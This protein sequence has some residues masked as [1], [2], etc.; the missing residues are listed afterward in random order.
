M[1]ILLLLTTVLASTPDWYPTPEIGQVSNDWNNALD[2]AISLLSQLTLPEKVNITTGQ[3]D[4]LCGGNT[5]GVPR[6]GIKGLCLQDGPVGVRGADFVN[7]FPCQNAMAATFDRI[8]TH[9]RGVAIGRQSRLKGVDVHL[10][11]VVGPIGRHVAGGRNWEG[12]SPDPYLSGQLVF[13]A[14]QGVQEEHVLATVKHFVGNEQERFRQLDEWVGRFN[15]TRLK[16]EIS[17]NIDD[18]AM[19]ELYMWPFAD[20]VRA[21]VAAVMCSYNGVNGTNSCQNSDLLNGRLKSEL[22]FQGFVMSDWFAQD[23]GVSNALAGLDMS[24]P[25]LKLGAS[26]PWGGQ[27]TRMVANGS[28]P[29]S[30]LDDMVLRILTPLIY[31]GVDK[32]SAPNFA[33]FT[34]KTMGIPYSGAS[35]PFSNVSGIEGVDEQIINYHVDVR[36]QFSA[37]VALDSARGAIVL[38][39]NDGILPLKNVSQISVFGVG[40]GDAICND[41]QCTEGALI[42]GWGSGTANPVHYESPYEAL[43]KKASLKNILVTGTTESWDMSLPR[44]LAAKSDVNIV[45]VLSSAGEAIVAVD[46]NLGD[47]NNISLWH[48]GDE[49]INTVASQGQTVVVVTTVGQVDM[50]SWISHPNI[51]AILWTAPSGDYGG[52]A[53]ADVLF[54]EVNPSGKLPYTIAANS[55]DY[56]PIIADIP[57]DGAPQA[58]FTEG[59]YLDYKWF[60]KQEKTPLYEFGYGLSYSRFSFSNMSINR[61]DILEFLPPRPE[62]IYVNKPESLKTP[63][64]ELYT[65]QG[66]HKIEGLVYPWID[67]SSVPL[68]DPGTP[69]SF[70]NGAGR[71]SDASGGVGGHPWLWSTAATVSHTT[72]NCGDVPGRVVSQLYVA[73]PQTTVDSPPV[74]LRGFDKSGLLNPGESQKTQYVLNWRDLAIWDVQL[75]S[76]R[77]Q[78]GEYKVYIGH[79]SRDMELVESFVLE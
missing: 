22:G 25:G 71:V 60:D 37:N 62:S 32:E 53:M 20:A 10:G 54:G 63:I 77:V 21:G 55:S 50:S 2:T 49:L 8:L 61:G 18:R 57:A 42:Q 68:T 58:D 56:I 12:F 4:G 6:L 41:L 45:Y 23:S 16:S 30:R 44:D 73:F 14:I 5:G 36:D 51:S 1:K 65:P 47:R 76:W 17:S 31:F 19:H 13:Q 67:D 59:I 33:G 28:L 3:G 40:S 72:T 70:A 9:Q 38:L 11:P 15:F 26:A 78:R 75:Q 48:N 79:S 74:Q 27:L 24:M 69:F 29:E 46:G 34:N 35:N 39:A 66:F 43:H 64:S 52:K 7:A